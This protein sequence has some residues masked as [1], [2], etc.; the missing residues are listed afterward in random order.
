MTSRR[1]SR[2]FTFLITVAGFNATQ[3]FADVVETKN[4]A[5][6]VG[7]IGKIDGGVVIV[8]TNY[9][10]TLSIKKAEVTAI[11]TDAPVTVRLETGTRL[12][13][14]ISGAAGTLQIAG[15][16]G[17]IN[18]TVE[19]VAAAWEQGGKDPQL[20]ALERGWAYEASV[21]VS[22]K[23]GTKSQLGT[24]TAL[25]ATLAG[26]NDMLAFYAAYD[27]HVTDGVKSADQFKAGSDYQSNFAGNNSWYVRDEGG[28]DRIKD[29]QFYNVA[30]AG[31]G[32]DF[33]KRPKQTFTGRLGL[34]FRTENHKNPITTDVNGVGLDMGLNHTLEMADMSLVNRFSF[35]PTFGDFG[36]FRL[37]H[38]SF[39]QL[40]LAA[41]NWKFRIGVNNDYN[42]KP[43]P[44]VDKLDTSYFARLVLNWK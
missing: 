16:D 25:R 37:T 10:G 19:K 39:L 43:G 38:E 29:I 23:S 17:T 12:T 32:Y 34:S 40:P 36:N 30:A 8:D 42:S 13:G 2:A 21:D 14:K 15:R 22:G 6:I 28:F 18:T 27:R 11:T 33:I 44:G 31:F 3:L 1:F 24:A 4:G 26:V 5:H 7:K 35:V 41:P 9:A 20:A